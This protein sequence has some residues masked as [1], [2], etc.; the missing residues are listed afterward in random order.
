MFIDFFTRFSNVSSIHPAILRLGLQYAEGTICGSNSRCV[1]LLAAMKQV[2]SDY[3]T[4]PQ[5]ELSR[6]LEA[7]IKPYI[8]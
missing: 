6:D 2:I 8:R 4:P 1:A 3:V 5:K 7:K